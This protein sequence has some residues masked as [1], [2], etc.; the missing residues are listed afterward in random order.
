MSSS[1]LSLNE[2]QVINLIWRSLKKMSNEE[3]DKVV[4]LSQQKE[5]W[6]KQVLGN[7][8]L[9]FLK[10][11]NKE[12][13]QLFLKTEKQEFNDF[14]NNKYRQYKSRYAAKI[15]AIIEAD[16]TKYE[17]G[18]RDGYFSELHSEIVNLSMNAYQIGYAYGANKRHKERMYGIM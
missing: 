9:D 1:N 18:Y 7:S 17:E 16:T 13:E 11:E 6:D 14:V 5:Y 4:E 12:N 2:K 10:I 3:I 15:N 8:L